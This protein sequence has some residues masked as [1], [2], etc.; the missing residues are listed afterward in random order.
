MRIS[1]NRVNTIDF[2]I[3]HKSTGCPESFA[4]RL[5][6]SKRTLHFTL[7]HMKD[8]FNAPIE[9][10]R[11]K[12]TYFYLE[13]GYVTVTFQKGKPPLEIQQYVAQ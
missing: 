2:L 5:G 12:K 7:S 4:K 13:D 9:Y 3:R 10:D 8:A 11:F 1:I 6:I